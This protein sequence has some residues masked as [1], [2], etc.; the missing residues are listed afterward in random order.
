MLLGSQLAA[1]LFEAD[2]RGELATFIDGLDAE[3][4][5]SLALAMVYVVL[6]SRE[7]GPR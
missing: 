2:V 6:F 7:G 1:R 4:A 5:R 3:E